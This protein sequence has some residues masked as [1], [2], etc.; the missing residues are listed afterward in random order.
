MSERRELVFESFDEVLA[1]VE[2]LAT[3]DVRVDGKHSFGKILRH[4]ALTND[5]V[6]GKIKAPKLPL[7]MRLAMPFMRKSILN[8]P[9]KPGFKLP[10]KADGFFWPSE[11]P[12][13]PDAIAYL[14]QSVENYKTNGPLPVHPIFG[15]AERAQVDQ[16]TLRHAAMHLGFVRPA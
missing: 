2:R 10:S 13:L 16:L 14:K 11:E 9:V 6:T 12:E 3:G 7:V 8:G 5:M 1:E 15:K 4:L